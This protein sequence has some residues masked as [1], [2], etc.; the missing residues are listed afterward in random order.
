MFNSL[1]QSLPDKAIDASE[2]FCLSMPFLDDLQH[3]LEQPVGSIHIARP[4][5][6]LLCCTCVYFLCNIL[7]SVVQSHS[8]DSH[9]H[10]TAT[11]SA[12]ALAQAHPTM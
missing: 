3:M 10:A 2:C 1:E 11:C 9:V 12:R 5:S 4:D 7:L 6:Q 8:D